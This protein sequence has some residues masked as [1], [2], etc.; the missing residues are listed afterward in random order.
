MRPLLLTFCL[1]VLPLL[2]GF[3]VNATAP[4]PPTTRYQAAR[5]TRY[6][7]AHGCP[8]AT[9]ANSPAF[10]RLKPLYALTIRALSLG[11]RARYG[12]LNVAFFVLLIPGLL[13]WLAYGAL[14]DA[15]TIHRL[16]RARRA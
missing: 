6:C 10:F 5:C 13:V 3:A 11:G 7:T 15:R 4:H 8:H 16:R 1:A 2:I 12:L 14:R 9:R